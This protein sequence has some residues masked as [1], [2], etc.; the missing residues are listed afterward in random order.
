[1]M[2]QS[3]LNPKRLSLEPRHNRIL[4]EDNDYVFY[5]TEKPLFYILNT[6][7]NIK[8]CFISIGNL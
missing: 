6:F 7:L 1:M 4:T 5:D 8:E 3:Y 2:T